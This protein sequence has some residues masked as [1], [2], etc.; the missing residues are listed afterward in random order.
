MAPSDTKLRS[1]CSRA[2]KAF[3]KQAVRGRLGLRAVSWLLGG[4][5]RCGCV[6]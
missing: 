4:V 5:K 1:E 2:S 3:T 6:D